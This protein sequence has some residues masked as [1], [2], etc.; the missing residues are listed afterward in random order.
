MEQRI[1]EIAIN[2]WPI[3]EGD[4][5]GVPRDCPVKRAYKHQMREATYKRISQEVLSMMLQM[6]YED[7][8]TI[9]MAINNYLEI[10]SA[11]IYK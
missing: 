6:K 9:K 3:H 5:Y 7:A 1:R 4:E 2:C 10:E 8:D 11:N